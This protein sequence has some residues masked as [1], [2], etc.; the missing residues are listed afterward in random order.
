MPNTLDVMSSPLGFRTM[1]LYV[2]RQEPKV[3]SDVK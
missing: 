1:S 3:V 2:T